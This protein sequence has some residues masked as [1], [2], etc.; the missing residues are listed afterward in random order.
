MGHCTQNWTLNQFMKGLN[1][2]YNTDKLEVINQ[3]T[4]KKIINFNNKKKIILFVGRLNISKGYDLFGKAITSVLNN[5][6]EWKAIVIGDEPRENHFFE[7][8]NLKILGFQKN[9]TVTKWYIKSDISV[10]CSRW[11]EPFGRTALEAS[12]AGCAVCL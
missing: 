9:N 5:N 3:S 12:S 4:S 8:K 10:V 1:K 6:P 11:D 2:K 7:H